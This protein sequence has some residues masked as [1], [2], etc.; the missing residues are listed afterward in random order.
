MSTVLPSARL[1]I[2]LS[3]GNWTVEPYF[4]AYAPADLGIHVTRMRMGSGGERG[5][6]EIEADALDCARLLADAAVDLIDLQGTGIMMER[7][8]DGE[9]SMVAAIEEASGTP[10]YTATGA[11]VEALRA[12]DM[13]RLVLVSPYEGASINRE[14]AFLE[15]SGFSVVNA[16]GL[17]R[18]NRSNEVSASDW[19][20]A[21]TGQDCSEADG[22][23]L[24]GSNTTMLEAVAPIEQAIGKPAVTSVQAALWA[25]VRRL[26]P[27]LSAAP[28]PPALGRLFAEA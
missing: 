19:V 16:I 10:A 21:A 7:G 24:S 5:Q 27:S 23:F 9:A 28:A 13:R 14:S 4:R 15:A 2:I 25:G 18:G 26:S 20:A 22:I 17:D 11:A 12:L 3:S 6:A 1:G 8:P